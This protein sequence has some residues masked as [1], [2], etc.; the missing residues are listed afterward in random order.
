MI[1]KYYADFSPTLAKEKLEV[2]HELNIS[3]S[4]LRTW[5]IEAEIWIPRVQRL[6]RVYQPRY[7]RS[8]YGE[9]IQIDGSD[10]AWF[11]EREPKCTLL[12]YIDDATS[13]LMMAQ[14]VPE[15]TTFTYFD[16]TKR[17]LLEHGKPIAFYS[18]KY[19]VFR[20]NRQEAKSGERITQFARALEEL[21]I[22]IIHANTCQA[23]GRVERANK[24][25]QDRLVKE[26]RLLG[27]STAQEGNDYLPKFMKMYNQKFA[28]PP[29]C[30]RNVHRVIK[31]E[32]RQKLE[33]IFTWQKE[34]IVS[35]NLT[36]Q[37]DMILYLLEDTKQNRELGGSMRIMKEK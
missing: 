3:V 19:S 24:T 25:L 6:K 1:N 8:C 29:K 22:D 16:A 7:R 30:E 20:V 31:E 5:M 18:D 37:Y 28:K 21:N 9:L 14:F 4:T 32:E 27:I 26:L 15:E 11:E 23:K 12:V 10:H 13:Q 34:R 36:L 17:Y 35:G 2:V 33:E